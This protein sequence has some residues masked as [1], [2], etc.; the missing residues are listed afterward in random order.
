MI[1]LLW[2]SIGFGVSDGDDDVPS[3]TI[4]IALFDGI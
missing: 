2:V 3:I 4:A 1:R